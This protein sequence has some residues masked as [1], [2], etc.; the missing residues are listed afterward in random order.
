MSLLILSQ[1]LHLELL[2]NTEEGAEVLL[3]DVDLAPVHEVQQ[4]HEVPVSHPLEEEQRVR[5]LGVTGDDVPEEGGAG[6]EHDLVGL[7]L[8]TILGD[9]A[10]I[11]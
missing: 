6:R 5:M 10:H 1:P 4:R 11:E 9:E 7:H 3:G 8:V 2:R